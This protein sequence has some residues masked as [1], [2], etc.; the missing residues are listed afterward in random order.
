[1]NYGNSD[2]KLNEWLIEVMVPLIWKT[3]PSLPILLYQNSNI[4]HKWLL[5]LCQEVK[6]VNFQGQVDKLFLQQDWIF[7]LFY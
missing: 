6:W 4:L 1:M 7:E 2:N 3:L 5:S